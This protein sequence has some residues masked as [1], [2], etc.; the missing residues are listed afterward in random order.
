MSFINPVVKSMNGIKTI[1]TSSLI[2]TDDNS[3]IKS[4]AG[5]TQAQQTGNNALILATIANNGKITD[6]D[7][8]TNNGDLTFTKQDN[9]T[10][11]E[12]LDNRYI[13]TSS[14]L[15]SDIAGNTSDIASLTTQQN[16]NTSDIASLTTQQ[17]TN[18]TDIAGNTSAIATLTTQQNTNTTDI[19][20]NTSAIAT[21]TTQQNTY[22]T[23][24]AGNT[25]AI[26]TLTTQQNT[27]TTDIASN[28]T[29]IGNLTTQQNTNTN[30]INGLTGT[31]NYLDFT[32]G[33]RTFWGVR[34]YGVDTPSNGWGNWRGI[35]NVEN[36]ISKQVT[37]ARF[38]G[39]SF[40]SN[41]SYGN[42]SVSAY[43]FYGSALG[44]IQTQNVS[45]YSENYINAE[46]MLIRS[47][48]RIKKNISEI[49][50]EEALKK[51]RLLKPKKYN[52]IDTIGRGQTEVFGFLAQEV[53]EVLPEAVSIGNGIIPNIYELCDVSNKTITLT[54]KST[55]DLSKNDLI[56]FIDVND[57]RINFKVESITDDKTFTIDGSFNTENINENQIFCMGKNIDDF[58]TLKK[59]TIFTITTASVQELDRKV[60]TLEERIERIERELNIT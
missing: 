33:G 12:N 49:N 39:N 14:S 21:L 20:G 59:D 10:I 35:L 24:I 53:R 46:G 57:K 8:D 47:D 4:S 58:H 1:E 29:D 30:N 7:F 42:T 48:E 9:T 23:D 52:Y 44:S 40:F 3:V 26:A 19:A 50:D 16:T 2:F 38:Q 41:L 18:T 56:E 32:S 5:I 51:L 34:V 13:L 54:D 17:N 37:G 22:T 55:S 60:L 15:V 43:Y 11:T 28:T 31:V 36:G 27:N 25:S 6:V 45:I